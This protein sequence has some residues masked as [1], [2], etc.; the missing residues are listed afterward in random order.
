MPLFVLDRGQPIVVAVM[1]V[2]IVEKLDVIEH[3]RPASLRVGY[4]FRLIFSAFSN[5]KKLSA[6]ALSWQQ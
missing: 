4:N 5:E 6:T 1:T 3:L 2:P